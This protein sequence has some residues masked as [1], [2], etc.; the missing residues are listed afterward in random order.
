MR[1]SA[2]PF[3]KMIQI[4]LSEGEEYEE[5]ETEDCPNTAMKAPGL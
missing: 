3:V 5:H 1:T 2:E 4:G